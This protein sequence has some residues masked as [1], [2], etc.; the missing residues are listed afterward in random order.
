MDKLKLIKQELNNHAD[1]EKAALSAKYFQVF[2][3]GYGEG[4]RFIGVTVPNQHRIAREYYRSISLIELKDLIRDPVHECRLTAILILVLK[5]EKAK[6]ETEKQSVVDYYLGNIDYINN[7]DLVDSSAHKIVGAYLFNKDRNLLYNLAR[8]GELW[9]QRIAVLSTFYF[10][11]NGDYTDSL[12]IAGLL[13]NHEHDLIHKAVGWMLRE[14][15]N[16]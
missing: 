14:V 3:G 7:W 16:R 13:L 15:G 9:Q 11:R 8:S 1:A 2:P 10:I 12:E 4:D 5:F 6:T